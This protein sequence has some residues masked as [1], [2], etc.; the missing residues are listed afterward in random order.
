MSQWFTDSFRAE[1]DRQSDLLGRFNLALFGKTGV[2]KS[3]LVNAIFGENVAAT[4]IGEPVTKGSHL[5]LD[6]RG[7]LGIVDT[8]GLEVG[9]D[10]KVLLQD[11]DK[12]VKEMR[13][14]PLPDQVHVAWYCVR[15]LDRR[16]EEAEAE[17]IR[18]ID[19]LGLPVICVFTQ[20]PKRGEQYHP[21][22][23]ALARHVE[24]LDLPIVGGRPFMTNALRDQ[25]SD[26]PEHG[27]IDLMRATFHV[28]PEAVH[29]A[30][31][32]AQKV[33]LAAKAK[34]ANK[35]IATA[36]TGAAAAAATPIPFSDA[37]MLVP[38]QLSMMARIA[39]L[40]GIRFD[41]AAMMAVASTSAATVGGRALF[42]NL[43]KLIPGAG[44]VAGGVVSA[45]VATSFTFAMGQAWLAVCQKAA[46]GKLRTLDGALDSQAVQDLFQQEFR[47]RMPTVRRQG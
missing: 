18:R 47:R 44:T 42:T 43:L 5:Y 30:L 12:M 28:A 16:F 2:G 27:L 22:A 4:G 39:H 26:Q 35:A 1:F 17:F 40:Y 29:G 13:K 20:V 6:R 19:D 14:K 36:A 41:R 31:A 21:D 3:T 33:D 25:F 15:G 24:S 8:Q 32:A 37:A 45:G 46:A 10:D 34:E 38:I 23:V 7:R 11:L 9:R